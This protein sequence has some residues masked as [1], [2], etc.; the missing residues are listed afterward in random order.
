MLLAVLASAFT[1]DLEWR[2]TFPPIAKEP[3]S[4]SALVQEF[5]HP[6]LNPVS[7]LLLAKGPWRHQRGGHQGCSGNA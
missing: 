2:A 7:E 4:E 3:D 5:G 6:P 1:A